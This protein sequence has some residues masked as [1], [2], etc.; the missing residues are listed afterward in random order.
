MWGGGRARG[1]EVGGGEQE[2]RIGAF[3][4]EVWISGPTIHQ[5]PAR[6]IEDG[7]LEIGGFADSGGRGGR[8]GNG[9][10]EKGNRR[11]GRRK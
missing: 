11:G 6:R 3:V 1:W 4:R 10:G 9:G 7:V 8:W 2:R 5:P